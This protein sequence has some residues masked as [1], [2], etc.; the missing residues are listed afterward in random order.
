MASNLTMPVGFKNAVSGDVEGATNG[1][2]AANQSHNFLGGD[3]FG[4]VCEIN[5]AGNSNCHLVLRG[6]ESPNYHPITV[7]RIAK[8][9]EEKGLAVRIMIDCSHD[10]SGQKAQNQI[11]VFNQVLE[12][13]K[14]GS[15]IFGV[16]LESHLFGGQQKPFDKE[17][18]KV[19]FKYGVSITDDCLS[20]SQT[21]EL[22]LAGYCS[23]GGKVEERKMT[24]VA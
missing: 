5:S 7:K 19:D 24:V 13:V 22:L 9:L 16:M 11:F 21:K 17:G 3:D 12:Q 6:G 8:K 20:W 14:R 23:L 4:Q 1:I 10:N 2:V 15:S 18:K